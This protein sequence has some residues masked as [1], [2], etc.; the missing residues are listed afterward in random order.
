MRITHQGV[1]IASMREIKD[2]STTVTWAE[3]R[4]GA[5]LSD[6]ENR[7]RMMQTQLAATKHL[8]AVTDKRLEQEVWD[9]K[10]EG[11]QTSP[12]ASWRELTRN[13]QAYKLATL[14]PLRKGMPLLE[15]R[16]QVGIQ[17]LAEHR[18][19]QAPARPRDS[20]SRNK[21]QHQGS[22]SSVRSVSAKKLKQESN[23]T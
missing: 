3:T 4:G 21:H 1:S 7:N 8:V 20:R 10:L 9:L 15:R 19:K 16:P 18:V 6:G 12:N 2:H 22:L 23:Q 5:G 11:H 17:Q 13:N 14:K